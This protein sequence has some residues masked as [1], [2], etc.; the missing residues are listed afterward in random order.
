MFCPSCG[1]QVGNQDRFC[2][3]CGKSLTNEK[4]TLLYSF[5]PFAIS[6]CFSRPGLNA[7]AYKNNTKIV[8]T[9]RRIYGTASTILGSGSLRFQVP[10]N[11]VLDSEC[12]NYGVQKTL[13]IQYREREN[14]KEVSILGGS[15][16]GG[17]NSRYV[18]HADELVR[19]AHG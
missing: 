6:V 5:G 9:D 8:V 1:E 18:T 4:E 3:S 13:W 2:P 10:Y 7:V 19:K 16:F 17:P 11:S 15:I 12:F 14:I